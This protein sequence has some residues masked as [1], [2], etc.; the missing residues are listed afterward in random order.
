MS[1]PCFWRDC[2]RTVSPTYPV[3]LVQPGGSHLLSWNDSDGYKD[4]SGLTSE[5]VH[6]VLCSR[7]C[8]TLLLIDFSVWLQGMH[9]FIIRM[10]WLGKVDP[11][12]T[13]KSL[14][15]I[16]EKHIKNFPLLRTILRVVLKDKDL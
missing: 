13:F 10:F 8:P 4:G 16:W 7:S 6:G 2:L 1:F 12:V 15:T 9:Q 3:C 5:G 11:E 14:A